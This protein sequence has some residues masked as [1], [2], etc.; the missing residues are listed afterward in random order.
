MALGDINGDGR[1]DLAVG[2]PH[3]SIGGKENA[4]SAPPSS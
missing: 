2:A 4:G 1:A 3:E